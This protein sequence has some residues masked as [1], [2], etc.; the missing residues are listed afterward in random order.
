MKRRIV[1][2][3]LATMTAPLSLA[4]AATAGFDP[5]G[6]PVFQKLLHLNTG[7]KS[8]TAHVDVETRMFFGRLALHG[9]LYNWG[10]NSKVVFDH[11][12]MLA[13]GAVEHQPSIEGPAEWPVRYTMTLLAQTSDATTYRLVPRESDNPREV[14]V[15]VQNASGLITQLVWSSA[16]GTITSDLTYESLDGYEL[17]AS[18]VTQTRGNGLNARSTST[19]S[20]YALNESIPDSII[21]AAR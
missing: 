11:V 5:G 12:P 13:K 21:S 17:V 7:L 9:T 14:D 10:S 8:Y 4:S 19:F 16:T 2:L 1:L 15:A 3:V 6:D 20:N 18:T